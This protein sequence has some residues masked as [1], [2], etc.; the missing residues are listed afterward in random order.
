MKADKCGGTKVRQ[1]LSVPV[2]N[3]GE[4]M[5]TTPLGFWDKSCEFFWDSRNAYNDGILFWGVFSSKPGKKKLCTYFRK[6]S[7][8]EL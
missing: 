8:T 4:S 3:L 1:L 5:E 7:V 6:H 2:G